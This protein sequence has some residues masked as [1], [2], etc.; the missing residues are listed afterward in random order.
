MLIATSARHLVSTSG[1]SAVQNVAFF[2]FFPPIRN[3]VEH[4]PSDKMHLL[5]KGT[6][7]D[8]VPPRPPSSLSEQNE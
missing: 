6:F 8:F 2:F 5:L 4:S 3:K 7:C 1:S